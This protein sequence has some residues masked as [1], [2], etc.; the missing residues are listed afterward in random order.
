MGSAAFADGRITP[1]D[2]TANAFVV[3]QSRCAIGAD[4]NSQSCAKDKR[5]WMIHGETP[6]AD[7]LNRKGLKGHAV[8]KPAKALFKC[9]GNHDG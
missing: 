1:A 5:L 8:A 9:L 7:K 6:A 4:E 3:E 2:E